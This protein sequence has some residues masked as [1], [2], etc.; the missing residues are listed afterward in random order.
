MVKL[1]AAQI[2]EAVET[3]LGISIFAE[4]HVKPVLV[5]WV[6]VFTEERFYVERRLR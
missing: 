5:F 2:A 6:N 3:G 1:D 4:S